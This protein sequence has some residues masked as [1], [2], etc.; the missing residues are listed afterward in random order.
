MFLPAHHGLPCQQLGC[1]TDF[2]CLQI[3]RVLQSHQICESPGPSL[4]ETPSE[5][6]LSIAPAKY[7][8][9]LCWERAK[10]L[11]GTGP[12]LQRGMP[13]VRLERQS[14]LEGQELGISLLRAKKKPLTESYGTVTEPAR[15]FQDAEQEEGFG[16]EEEEG[17]NGIQ[18]TVEAFC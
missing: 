2:S 10:Q 3:P 16:G 5:K 17:E 8:G 6:I 14:P 11:P 12:S 15:S 9:D 7:S 4:G 1:Y 13:Q 18:A